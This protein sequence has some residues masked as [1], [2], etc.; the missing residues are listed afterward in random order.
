MVS[1]K[2]GGVLQL[3]IELGQHLDDFRVRKCICSVKKESCAF[4]FPRQGLILTLDLHALR[5][6]SGQILPKFC[7]ILPCNRDLFCLPG[8]CSLPPINFGAEAGKGV[9]PWTLQT[10]VVLLGRG[11]MFFVTKQ[12]SF[13]FLRYFVLVPKKIFETVFFLMNSNNFCTSDP[14][15][16]IPVRLVWSVR[17][18]ITGG[19]TQSMIMSMS[20]I[21]MSGII[22]ILAE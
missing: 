20:M 2:G 6:G 10:L 21:K 7:D 5:N 13:F 19:R 3:R 1:H 9:V 11:I 15:G 22:C 18:E 16:D 14:L 8:I 12:E 17:S 4:Q